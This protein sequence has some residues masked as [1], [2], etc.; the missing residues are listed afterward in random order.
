MDRERLE[1]EVEEI[2]W[3]F[4]FCGSL[5]EYVSLLKDMGR[6]NDRIDVVDKRLLQKTIN[7]LLDT[8]CFSNML[9]YID[10]SCVSLDGISVVGKNL[11]NTN[12]NI[13]PQKVNNKTPKNKDNIK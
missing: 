8:P 10:L 5:Y 7:F 3:E 11:S 2:N 9:Q 1:R 13:D 12:I 4:N 6:L